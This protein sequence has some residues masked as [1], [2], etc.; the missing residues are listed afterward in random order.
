MRIT[1]ILPGFN[2]SGGARVLAVYADRLRRRGHQVLA[3]A[4]GEPRPSLRRVL[5][6]L[7]RGEGWPSRD[8]GPSHFDGVGVERRLLDHPGPVTDADLPDAD[9]VIATWWETAL[10][11]SRLAPAKGVAVHFIQGY[12]VYVDPPETVDPAYRLP[13]PKIVISSWLRNLVQQHFGQT[14]IAVIPNSVDTATFHAP[15]RGRQSTPTVGLTYSTERIKGCDISLRAYEQARA[16]LPNLRL[17]S[18][19]NNPVSESLPLPPGAEFTFHARDEVLRQVYAGCDVWL[20]G[21]REEG[22]GL[23]ILEAMAC[24]TPVIAAPAG[25]APEL[26]AKGGGVLVPFEDV[27]AMARAI[28][29]ICTLPDAEWRALSDAALANARS[30]TWDDA[31]AMMEAALQQAA[32]GRTR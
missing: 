25:A 21:S 27:P 16:E 1:F 29:Q 28:V 5:G 13:L 9:V 31:V 8:T 15:P 22:F 30:F 19:G 11:A 14:P 3:V 23:P 12:D 17:V 26:L 18:M 24:R 2:L 32:A 4:P 20:S 10:W 6:A 7:L